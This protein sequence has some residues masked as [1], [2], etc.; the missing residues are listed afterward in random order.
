LTYL[1]AVINRG[2]W[3]WHY[4]SS[5]KVAWQCWWL[6]KGIQRRGRCSRGWWL[7]KCNNNDH[8]CRRN[9]CGISINH[10]I[11]KW[12]KIYGWSHKNYMNTNCT[13]ELKLFNNK[14]LAL[15][16]NKRWCFPTNHWK[17]W[18]LMSSVWISWWFYG[19]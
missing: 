8:Q 9:T 10:S 15:L 14:R 19:G 11:L 3:H 6:Y 16:P 13:Q 7:S 4:P 17:G 2:I 12:Q 5:K 18:N 1:M